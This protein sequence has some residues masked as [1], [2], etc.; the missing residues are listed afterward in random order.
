MPAPL[1]RRMVLQNTSC[2]TSS[3]KFN[4]ARRPRQTRRK[5]LPYD[6]YPSGCGNLEVDRKG[7]AAPRRIEKLWWRLNGQP[8]TLTPTPTFGELKVTGGGRTDAQRIL[9]ASSLSA[10]RGQPR[11]SSHTNVKVESA[12]PKC[13][14]Y[15]FHTQIKQS[16]GLL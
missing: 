10:L 9:V 12:L 16:A 1:I 3:V 11:P 2:S 4:L 15:T 14:H 8:P 13:R 7:R 6:P 5:T